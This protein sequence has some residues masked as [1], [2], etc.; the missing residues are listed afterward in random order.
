[1]RIVLVA[2]LICLVAGSAY[3]YEPWSRESLSPSDSAAVAWLEDDV[4]FVAITNDSGSRLRYTIE[5]EVP[6][7]TAVRGFPSFT[8]IVPG[9][10]VLLESARLDS[11]SRTPR[12][13]VE[14]EFIRI[15]PDRQR[16]YTIPVKKLDSAI[17]FDR[18]VLQTRERLTASLDL[19]LLVAERELDRIVVDDHYQILGSRDSGRIDITHLTS[20]L[21]H[22]RRTNTITL[23]KP[24]MTLEMSTPSMRGTGLLVFDIEW[25]DYRNRRYV[26]ES[27]M[28]LVVGTDYRFIN[29]SQHSSSRFSN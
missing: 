22:D 12:G 6:G 24:Q 1:M 29:N 2:L 15:T 5:P 28:A 13:A 10:T 3:A 8:T 25:Y 4:L 9:S 27:P 21:E 19:G 18:Y 23:S 20:G 11:E 17:N 26:I 7:R 14:L 16:S